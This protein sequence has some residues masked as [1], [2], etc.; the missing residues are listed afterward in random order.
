MLKNVGHFQPDTVKRYE[1]AHAC[2]SQFVVKKMC[3][4]HPY[5]RVATT[6]WL[7]QPK[8]PRA[9]ENIEITARIKELYAEHRGNSRFEK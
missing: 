5:L 1:A 8:S 7:R 4:S 6:K 2:H 9:L 3:R